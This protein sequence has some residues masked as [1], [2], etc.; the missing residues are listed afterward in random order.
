MG[1][2][3]RVVWTEL[4]L[5]E[6]DETIDWLLE[7]WTTQIA[8]RFTELVEQ[9]INAIKHNPLMGAQSHFLKECRKI[10]VPPYHILIYKVTQDS[11]EIIRFFDG[12]Q[13]P[14]KLKK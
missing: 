1:K 12:R 3:K 5:L 6:Y 9:K 11:I 10:W 13:N 14:E 4:A 7:N 8:I 2:N